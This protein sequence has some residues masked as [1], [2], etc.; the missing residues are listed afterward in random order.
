MVKYK[1]STIKIWPFFQCFI[2]LTSFCSCKIRINNLSN[3][4]L[5]F[6]YRFEQALEKFSFVNHCVNGTEIILDDFRE[7][8][9][10]SNE[11]I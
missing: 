6:L 8:Y 11:V 7:K 4:G 9:G 1:A 2:F 10:Y 3:N 5:T